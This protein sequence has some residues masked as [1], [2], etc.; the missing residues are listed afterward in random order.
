MKMGRPITRNAR[1]HTI[2]LS[3]AVWNWLTASGNASVKIEELARE[4]MNRSEKYAKVAERLTDFG[5][6]VGQIGIITR[7][8]DVSEHYDWLMTASKEEIE[9]AS[10]PAFEEE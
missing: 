2:N 3:D 9:K 10:K 8:W 1:P 6:N 5:Y 7:W 4:K